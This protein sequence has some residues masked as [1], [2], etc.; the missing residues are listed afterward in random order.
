MFKW[1]S[2]EIDLLSL[3]LHK[4]INSTSS[5]Q[6][7]EALPMVNYTCQHSISFNQDNNYFPHSDTRNHDKKN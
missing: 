2:N 1:K 4:Q 5:T 7:Y 3:D 6:P